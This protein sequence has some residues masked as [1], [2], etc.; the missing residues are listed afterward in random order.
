MQLQPLLL[1]CILYTPSYKT[2]HSKNASTEVSNSYAA[3]SDLT[4]LLLLDV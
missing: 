2:F 1:M 4:L 3:V